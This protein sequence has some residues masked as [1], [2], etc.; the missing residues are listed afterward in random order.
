LV[1]WRLTTY[2]FIQLIMSIKIKQSATA[3]QKEGFQIKF[4]EI[5]KNNKALSGQYTIQF[6]DAAGKSNY[7]FNGL[8]GKS[9][10]VLVFL[11]LEERE[12]YRNLKSDWQ[13]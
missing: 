5:V 3:A 10:N 13:D 2:S 8:N 1:K 12:E 9:M 6:F 11:T 4:S 7:V